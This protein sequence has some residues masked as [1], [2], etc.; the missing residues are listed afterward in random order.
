MQ[1]TTEI[2]ILFYLKKYWFQLSLICLVLYVMVSKDLSFQFNINKPDQENSIELPNNAQKP[3]K[4]EKE[5]ITQNSSTPSVAKSEASFFSKIPFIGGGGKPSG[6]KSELPQVDDFAV[7]S[8][9]KRFAHVAISER[10]KYGVP[11]S[12]IIANALFH[13][14]AGK[15]DM[16]QSGHNHFAIPCSVDWTGPNGT[17]TGMCYRHYENAWTS[18]RDHSLYVTSGKFTKLRR[19]GTT[20]YKGWAKNLEAEGFSE[21][22]NLEKNLLQLIEK[23]DL[24]QLDFQ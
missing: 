7:Q 14:Y 21:F 15:R 17:Y 19:L 24:S 13:S 11:S 22:E 18:F 8:Y 12:I 6:K 23:Y 5:L 1:K 9:I 20:D 3:G 2:N 4:K 10:K 16:A